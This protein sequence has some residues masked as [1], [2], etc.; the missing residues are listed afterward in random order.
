[1]NLTS[2]AKVTRVKNAAA[3][4]NSDTLLS[5]VID[6]QGF[7]SVT[8]AVLLGSISGNS[9]AAA[10]VYGK[11]S[12]DNNSFSALANTGVDIGGGDDNKVVMLEIVNPSE[13]YVKC[14][15]ERSNAAETAID[16]IIAI[17]TGGYVEAVTQSSTVLSSLVFASPAE[18][19]V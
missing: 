14:A 7:T 3:A 10:T 12:S 2:I 11:Q 13:R 15:V 17:Q 19:A 8:F 9:S 16:G 5:D 18:G 4:G 1:M 6:M